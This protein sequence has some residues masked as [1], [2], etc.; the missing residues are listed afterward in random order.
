MGID[1]LGEARINRKGERNGPAII[2]AGA[3]SLPDTDLA[4]QLLDLQ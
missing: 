1:R 2:L 3:Q 4:A